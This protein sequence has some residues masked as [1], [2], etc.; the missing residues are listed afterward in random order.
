MAAAVVV[1]WDT[2]LFKIGLAGAD[3]PTVF[4]PILGV[5]RIYDSPTSTTAKIVGPH[6]TFIGYDAI[7]RCDKEDLIC[8]FD[9]NGLITDFESF[10]KL[11]NY[12]TNQT[13]IDDREHWFI[14]IESPW[15]TNAQRT[16]FAQRRFEYDQV[17]S[18]L[19][20]LGAPF[21]LWAQNCNSGIVVDCGNSQ[22]SVIPIF[23]GFSVRHS[24]TKTNFGGK[25]LTDYMCD[26]LN[27]KGAS[28]DKQDFLHREIARQCKQQCGVLS[29]NFLHEVTNESNSS[30]FQL[31]DGR[32]IHCNHSDAMRCGEAIFQPSVLQRENTLGIHEAVRDC[33]MKC[34][35]YFRPNVLQGIAIDGG[36]Q[37][38]GFPQRL[39]KE[40]N[41]QALTP[42]IY[43][44]RTSSW[45]EASIFGSYLVDYS[46]LWLT[47]DIYQE[48]GPSCLHRWV[49]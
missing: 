20:T 29:L 30:E 6:D 47:A 38:R 43:E 22:H 35:I 4:P 14:I 21:L 32:V 37:F 45:D 33:I 44:T 31:P 36:S 23:D 46:N 40:L 7:A 34:D 17:P 24:L 39:G 11:W 48:F 18:M 5:P 25:H 12:A 26:L 8:P 2:H 28:L 13:Q 1:D 9:D 10:D 41:A 49:I 15:V 3:Q 27:A 42:N 19:F 16:Q